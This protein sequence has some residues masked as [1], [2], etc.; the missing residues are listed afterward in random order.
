M[1]IPYV[2]EYGCKISV[3]SNETKTPNGIKYKSFNVL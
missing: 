2:Y 1:T 3:Q